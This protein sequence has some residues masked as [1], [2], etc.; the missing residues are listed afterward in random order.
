MS[1]PQL[2]RLTAEE[3]ARLKIL[4][5]AKHAKAGGRL[6]AIDGSHA[7]YHHELL[8][9]LRAIGVAVEAADRFED[10]FERR[11]ADFVFPLL[12]RAGFQNSE[13]LAPLLLERSGT[14]YLGASPIIRGLSDDK[15]L[16]KQL[17]RAHGVET[18]DWAIYRRGQPVP[19][20]AFAGPMI[21]KPNASSASWGIAIADS[22]AAAR[23][24]VDWLHAERHD[25]I[26]EPVIP[27]IDVAMPVVGGAEGA[28]LLPPLVYPNGFRTYAEKR[29]LVAVTDDPL[30]PLAD[31]AVEARLETMTRALMT[32]LWP[33]D[34]GRFEYRYNPASGRL[35]FME[36]N[37][38]CNLW[39]KKTIS[40]SAALIGVDH[41]PLVETILTHSLL[42]QNV[43][44]RRSVDLA[45]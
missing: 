23:E 33:F 20:P 27:A 3:K 8:E 14:P 32:E 45:A 39:S 5:L 16:M 44:E 4:F 30:I 24:Q 31:P 38:N 17:A 1:H 40:R 6:D 22:W 7:L 21:V 2:L 10:I 26:V 19:Q 12:N 9:T 11:D 34:Y 35:S 37:V 43:I 42:R 15:H 18:C 36:V 25:A 29:N 28:W 13:M 41:R